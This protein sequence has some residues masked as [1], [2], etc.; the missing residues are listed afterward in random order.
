MPVVDYYR[1][2]HKVVEID[3]SPPIDEVYGK[4]R[5]AIDAALAMVAP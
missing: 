3:S 5:I 2:R 4:I 1:Q